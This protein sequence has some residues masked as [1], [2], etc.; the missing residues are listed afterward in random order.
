M[1]VTNS[2]HHLWDLNLQPVCQSLEFHTHTK[3]LSKSQR[4]SKSLHWVKSY[5]DF[6]E[7]GDLSKGEIA[8]GRVCIFSLR[9]R[10][11]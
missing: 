9:S 2:I 3:F 5:E 6:D 8:L 4:A 11:I 1:F 7:R 10:L